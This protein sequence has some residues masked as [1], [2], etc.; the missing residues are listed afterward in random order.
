MCRTR[1]GRYHLPQANVQFKGFLKY[2]ASI[3]KPNDIVNINLKD[4]SCHKMVPAYDH[5]TRINTC[6]DYVIIKSNLPNTDL[7]LQTKITDHQAVLC[8]LNKKNSYKRTSLK[9]KIKL[10]TKKEQK[11]KNHQIQKALLLFYIHNE[12]FRQ[13]Y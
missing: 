13:F 4:I 5:P 12:K 10:R 1:L 7:V 8:S 3:K 9:A 11:R 6:L 2:E